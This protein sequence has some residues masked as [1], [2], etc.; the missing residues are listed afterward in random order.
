[1]TEQQPNGRTAFNGMPKWLQ[2]AVY[3]GV[4][5]L[6]ALFLVYA[7]TVQLA[8]R[9][10]R[11]EQTQQLNTQILQGIN[12]LMEQRRLDDKYTREHFDDALIR[13]ARLMRRACVVAAT[14]TDER[15]QCMAG[16]DQ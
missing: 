8:D 9:M 10:Q 15:S 6:I 4:P 1:M 12:Q 14:T 2:A 5:S 13:L 11:M 3:L 16:T 7:L